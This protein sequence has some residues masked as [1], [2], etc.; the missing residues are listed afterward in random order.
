MFM[1]P[2]WVILQKS[3]LNWL[4]SLL[5]ITIRTIHYSGCPSK[6]LCHFRKMTVLKLCHYVLFIYMCF[7]SQHGYWYC[8]LS[9]CY[10]KCFCIINI[11]TLLLHLWFL[12]SL[13]HSWYWKHGSRAF[14]FCFLI[15]VLNTLVQVFVSVFWVILSNPNSVINTQF[16]TAETT[17]IRWLNGSCQ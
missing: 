4:Y 12:C 3:S 13:S 2:E 16:S 10:D 11:M 17:N 1:C 7:L 9:S 14:C 5:Y 15:S 6:W 8:N